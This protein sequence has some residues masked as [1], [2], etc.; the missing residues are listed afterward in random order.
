MR[1]LTQEMR[2]SAI[3]VVVYL[4]IIAVGAMVLNYETSLTKEHHYND[5]RN[6][7]CDLCVGDGDY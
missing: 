5:P 1:T 4:S 6:C 3:V 7:E 2:E